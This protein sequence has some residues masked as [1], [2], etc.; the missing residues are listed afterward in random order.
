VMCREEENIFWACIIFLPGVPFFRRGFILARQ[1]DGIIG[2]PTFWV[3]TFL[4]FCFCLW[5]FWEVMCL[6][7]FD[8]AVCKCS[9]ESAPRLRCLLLPVA[10]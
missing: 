1:T 10:W 9:D 2:A 5:R 3:F 8:M 6:V 4:L 7:Q